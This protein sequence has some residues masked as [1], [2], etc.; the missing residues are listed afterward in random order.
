MSLAPIACEGLDRRLICQHPE[1]GAAPEVPGLSARRADGFLSS[2][3]AATTGAEADRTRAR[4]RHDARPRGRAASTG[5]E[6]LRRSRARGEG[7]EDARVR[8]RRDGARPRR[9][10]HL[11]RLGGLGGA[12]RSAGRLP[13]RA[14]ASCSTRPMGYKRALYGHFGQGCVH[15]RIDFDLTSERGI[16]D[17]RRV[18]ERGRR[19]RASATAARSRASTATA[20]RAR[21][22]LPKMFGAELVR[23]FREFKAHLGSRPDG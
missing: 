17:Y 13:A 3:S 8:P 4:R 14:A 5:D 18:H 11:A 12:P 19:P 1:E 6:A 16:G 9:G 7:L 20:R 23:A 2:S 15:C 21:E 10:G 22:L